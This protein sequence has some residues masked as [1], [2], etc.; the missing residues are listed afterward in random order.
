MVKRNIYLNAGIR[1]S[2]PGEEI[3]VVTADYRPNWKGVFINGV[4]ND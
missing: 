2:L 1:L 4:F 3:K